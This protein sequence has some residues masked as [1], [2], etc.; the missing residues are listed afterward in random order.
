GKA[1][2]GQLPVLEVDG[3]VIAQSFS[4]CRFVANEVGLAPPTN[5]EKAQADMI[6]DGCSDFGAKLIPPRFEKD[7][8]KKAELMKQAEA[9]TPVFL[10]YFED[11]LKANNGGQGYFAGAK[12]RAISSPEAAILL[13]CA[14][15]RDICARL[16]ARQI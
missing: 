11:I 15:Y 2:F 10:K 4:I 16:K 1:P 9:A 5:L 3:K 6:V 14:R 12:V 13:F 8:A 7:E